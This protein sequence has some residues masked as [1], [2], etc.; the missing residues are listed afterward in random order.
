MPGGKKA[1]PYASAAQRGMLHHLAET[2]E[3][4][5]AEV[6]RKDKASKGLRLP[7]KVKAKKGKAKR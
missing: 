4:D 1:K 6:R 7:Q 3:I 5:P 2:G